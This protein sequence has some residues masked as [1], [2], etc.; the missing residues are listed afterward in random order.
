MKNRP[1][2]GRINKHSSLCL[3][4]M[5]F[6]ISELDNILTLALGFSVSKGSA[7][8]DMGNWNVPDP[9][10]QKFRHKMVQNKDVN[11]L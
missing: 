4:E 6:P 10:I 7:R 3:I 11:K 9:E 1:S 5:P 2:V 8:H